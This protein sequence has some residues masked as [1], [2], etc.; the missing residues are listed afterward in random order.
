MLVCGPTWMGLI[1]LA[2]RQTM[3][4]G[5]LPGYAAANTTTPRATSPRS[6]SSKPWLIS[7]SV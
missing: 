2:N 1:S 7:S 4:M 3:R 6:S 5:G